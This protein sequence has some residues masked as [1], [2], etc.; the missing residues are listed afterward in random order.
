MSSNTGISE[1][2][3][4]G[5][6]DIELTD[7]VDLNHITHTDDK[8]HDSS[9]STSNSGIG[10]TEDHN[11][12]EIQ[13]FEDISRI[14]SDDD[15]ESIFKNHDDLPIF[16]SSGLLKTEYRVI[17]WGEKTIIEETDDITKSYKLR[18]Q[19]ATT[20]I[21]FT[22]VG[23]TDATLGA[24]MHYIMEEYDVNREN[25][26]I[27]FL[28][29]AIG[30]IIS[31][32]S[33]N[34]LQSRIGF[35]GSYLLS[36][37]IEIVFCLGY[38]VKPPF[39]L[40]ILT[41]LMG[42]LGTGLEESSLNLF[43]GNLKY[44]NEL[45]GLLHSCY[46]VGCLISPILVTSL[47]HKGL[48]WNQYYLLLCA[49]LTVSAVMALF[50]FKNETKE[51]FNYF[52]AKNNSKSENRDQQEQESEGFDNDITE[53]QNSDN[54]KTESVTILNCILNPYVQFFAFVLFIYEGS[55]L[56][57]GSWLYNYYLTIKNRTDTMASYIT[58]TYWF[59]MTLGRIVLAFVT[60][61]YFEDK[62]YKAIILYSA[63][64]SIGCLGFTIFHDFFILQIM[65]VSLAGFCVGPNFATTIVISIK[66]LP[67]KY[68][69]M[70]VG[71]IAGFGGS[72]A[73]V[74]PSIVGWLSEN[75]AGGAGKGLIYFP[76]S[77][78]FFFTIAT[79]SWLFFYHINNKK[80]ENKYNEKYQRIDSI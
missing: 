49:I 54:S 36:L 33:M 63:G 11:D 59:F 16:Q 50:L 7:R 39:S 40:L 68:S 32:F 30:Y 44:S 72:G 62:E 61:K 31:S 58:S 1:D 51:K 10:T 76:F 45:L 37:I 27:L 47:I 65:S 5:N 15:D 69:N 48:K 80:L 53:L 75:T 19:L 2:Q 41:A 3:I 20:F 57:I 28:I 26:S 42:G 29:Q 21:S 79:V 13:Y 12:G 9:G 14:S 70:G 4:W 25:V 38:F 67:K 52:E 6:N 35:Y 17:H 43:V 64:V 56:T 60:G 24:V 77:S 22:M 66:T 74:M 8:T 23:F 46:G 71:I 55:E 18:L 34:F 78:F 73:A